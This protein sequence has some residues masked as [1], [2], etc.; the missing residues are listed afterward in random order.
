MRKVLKTALLLA[1]VG[2]TSAAQ[3]AVYTI[4]GVLGGSSDFGASSFHDASG[5]S[6]MVGPTVA[7]I[8]E[9]PGLFGTYDDVSGA[10]HATGLNINGG[11]SF[12]LDGTLLF[13]ADGLLTANSVLN[14]TFTGSSLSDTTLGFLAGFVCCG[15]S[16]FPPNSF[17]PDGA[18]MILTLWGADFSGDFLSTGSYTGSQ[19]GMDLRLGMSAAPVPAA[20][21]LFGSG[22]LGLFGIARKKA[23]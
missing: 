3:A 12:S 7:D 6:P 23:A 21:W 18:N 1:A 4:T 11:A 19:L 20:V 8:L 15:S 2:V 14:V 5:S 17:R 22:L 16:G 13:D 9:G 10:L